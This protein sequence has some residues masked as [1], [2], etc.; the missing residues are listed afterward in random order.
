MNIFSREKMQRIRQYLFVIKELSDRELRRR[1]SRSRLGVVWSVLQPLL[2]MVVISLVFTRIFDRGEINGPYPIYYLC[3]FIVWHMFTEA[4]NH[5]MTALVDN[6]LML[7]RVKFPMNVFVLSRV[8]TAVVNFL[9]TLVA[10]AAMLIV[11]RVQITWR[12]A[13]LP[14]I[15]VL[16]LFFALGIAYLISTAYVFFGD[17]RHLYGELLTLWMYLSALFYPVNRLS[18]VM[19]SILSFNPVF[20]CIDSVR[21]IVMWGMLPEWST[22]LRLA[23]FAGGFYGLGRWVFVRN[24]ENIMQ[25]L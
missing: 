17:V 19:Q 24:R 4:T 18:P 23:I 14:L 16:E 1:Y 8:T 12:I 13:L 5:S 10:F 11:F 21:R 22:L 15:V 3:G 7:I 2:H 6:R 20:L 25:E 9:Y